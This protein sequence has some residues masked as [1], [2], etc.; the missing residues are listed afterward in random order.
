M[1]FVLITAQA[2]TGVSTAGGKR[3]GDKFRQVK[4]REA[5]RKAAQRDATAVVPADDSPSTHDSRGEQQSQT[6]SVPVEAKKD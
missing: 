6:E 5:A 4:A 2:T 3:R 1:A